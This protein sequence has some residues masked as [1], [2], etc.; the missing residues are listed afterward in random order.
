MLFVMDSA[1]FDT[2]QAAHMPFVKSF[3]EPREAWAHGTFT[4]PSHMAMMV[5]MLPHS[6]E[7]QPLYNRYQQQLWR[8]GRDRGT[9]GH[10]HH[11]YPVVGLDGGH[12]IVDG[13]R[14]LGY[15][16]IGTG[17][18]SWF[19]HPIW[20]ELFEQFAYLPNATEQIR[21]LQ[22]TL[23][24]N[25]KP[26]FVFVNFSETHEPYSHGNVQYVM[27][28]GYQQHKLGYGPVGP[29][30]FC[31]LHSRQI[32]AAEYLDGKIEEVWNLMP[33]RTFGVLTAD[34]GECFGEEGF[35]G[36]GFYHPL[37]LRVPLLMM[38]Q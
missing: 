14:R 22:K 24:V 2:V 5:G 7:E 27:P 8:L 25:T 33:P 10:P 38:A 13:F 28:P 11:D 4:W 26:H 3:G 16:T 1:R 29:D 15:A 34:H 31:E 9:G 36:H 37:V 18:V 35:F 6:F 21:W 20:R 23:N 17:A 30:A 19:E 32:R 12:S